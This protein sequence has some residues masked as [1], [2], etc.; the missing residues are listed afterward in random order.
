MIL[1]S[2]ASLGYNLLVIATVIL[3]LSIYQK[4]WLH[5]SQST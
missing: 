1:Q 3:V 2:I 4:I 5:L